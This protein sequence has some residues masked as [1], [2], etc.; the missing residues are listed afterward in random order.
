M[1]YANGILFFNIS[2][3][4]GESQLWKS[5]GTEA[6]TVKI[7]T[8]AHAPE[9]SYTIQGKMFFTSCSRTQLWISDGTEAGTI[10]LQEIKPGGM[11]LI[12]Q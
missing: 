9:N 7:K 1:D 6:G 2:L 10:L 12:W 3:S 4:S 5:D 11:R 8:L